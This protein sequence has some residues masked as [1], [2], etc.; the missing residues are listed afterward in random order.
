ML[1]DQERFRCTS[2]HRICRCSCPCTCSCI[3]TRSCRRRMN[4]SPSQP[5]VYFPDLHSP[6][7]ILLA[8]MTCLLKIGIQMHY[9]LH[10]ADVGWPGRI[11]GA[12]EFAGSGALP[13][14][15]PGAGSG[16]LPCIESAGAGA[17][18]LTL[19]GEGWT[20]A[21]PRPRFIFQILILLL[22]YS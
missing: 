7:S 21:P 22:A 5:S 2:I 12:D 19:P 11:S 9:I 18:A 10:I 14:I 13:C 4:S 8:R 3:C 15:E 17:L 6:S 1:V 16:A 20:V